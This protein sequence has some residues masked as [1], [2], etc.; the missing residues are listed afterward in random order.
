[1]GGQRAR[2]GFIGGQRASLSLATTVVSGF[3]GLACSLCF[4]AFNDSGGGTMANDWRLGAA[5][6]AIN[7][8]I[9]KQFFFIGAILLSTNKVA[10]RKWR[11]LGRRFA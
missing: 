9:V 8:T 2:G 6:A 10:W 11:N 3:A 4:A 5:R 1:M 7:N